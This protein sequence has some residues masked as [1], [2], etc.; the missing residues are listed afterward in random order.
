MS[1]ETDILERWTCARET[2]RDDE[3]DATDAR[4]AEQLGYNGL[5]AVHAMLDWVQRIRRQGRQPSAVEI[6]AQLRSLAAILNGEAQRD[7]R[8]HVDPAIDM[9]G[10]KLAGTAPRSIPA[11]SERAAAA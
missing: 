8:Q 6:T 9:P 11:S 1:R 7:L 10:V 3:L 5:A 2:C 4:F